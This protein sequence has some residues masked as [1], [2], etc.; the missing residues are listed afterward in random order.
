MQLNIAE[1]LRVSSYRHPNK[2]AVL[3]EAKRLTFGELNSR[4]NRLANALLGMGLEQG[5][6]VGVILANVI[7]YVEICFG[8]AKAG[9]TLVPISYRLI[10]SEVAFQLNHSDSR[11]LIA[12]IDYLS[13]VEDA[14]ADLGTIEHYLVVGESIPEGMVA[15]EAALASAA[16]SE[17][18]NSLPETAPFFIGYTS[19]TTGV[20][21]GAVISHRSRVLTFF[22]M[23]AEYGCYTPDDVSL[24]V[25]PIYHGAGMAFALAPVYFGGAVSLLKS[26][27][28]EDVIRLLEIDRITNVFLVPT[29]FQAIFAL[30]E[31]SRRRYRHPALKVIMSNAA[32]LPQA[33]KEL[34]VSEWP[35]SGLYE[36]YG[37][38]E[39]GIVTTLRPVDQL[40]KNQCVGQPFPMTIIKLLDDEG[41]EVEM[42]EVGELFS[43]SPYLLSGYH[44]QPEALRESLHGQYFSAGDM[45]MV[46]DEGYFYIVDRKK[47]MIVTGGVNVYPREVEEVLFRH[48]KIA[49]VAV[50]GVADPYWGEAV[51]AVVVLKPTMK[52]STEELIHFCEGKL[53]RFKH[54]SKVEF[55]AALPRNSAGKV[56]K[57]TL[58]GG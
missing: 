9:L 39:G 37:S 6:R 14:K 40:R 36:L 11:A 48:P 17:P 45:A 34:I 31:A 49:D 47:D 41:E 20:P 23:A 10:S 19:G 29:M 57:R 58:R 38:T 43:H 51:K 25:A 35:M 18:P 27:N 16:D 56:L 4:A 12:G 8:L 55:V 3:Q 54:P 30:P 26:F 52:A 32:P 1:G 21:K 33:T 46:D 28:A 15:Y 2:V 44:K 22:S 42:G 53:A 24:A 5:D 7:E 50:I 13:A